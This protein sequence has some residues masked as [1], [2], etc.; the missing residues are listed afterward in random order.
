MIQKS[1]L[2]HTIL[3]LQKKTLILHNVIILIKSVFNKDK[4]YYCNIFLETCMDQFP[5]NNDN[6]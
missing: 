5:K 3:C 1:T 6:K 2:F 4:N